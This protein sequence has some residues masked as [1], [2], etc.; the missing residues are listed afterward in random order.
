MIDYLG[1]D[2]HSMRHVGE[3]ENKLIISDTISLT[4]TIENNL[5]FK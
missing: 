2:I 5:F 4:N 1:S 3:F